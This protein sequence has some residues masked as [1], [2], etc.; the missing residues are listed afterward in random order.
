L[1][2]YGSFYYLSLFARFIFFNQAQQQ[3]RFAP[4]FTSSNLFK[5]Q[6]DQNKLFLSFQGIN[7]FS[8]LLA[9]LLLLQVQEKNCSYIQQYQDSAAA[10]NYSGRPKFDSTGL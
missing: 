2:Y 3:D 6:P 1:V 10:I 5:P 9:G 8:V 4:N 7:V